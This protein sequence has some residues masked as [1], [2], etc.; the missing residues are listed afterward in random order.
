M[1][2]FAR[3]RAVP[4][5]RQT[6]AHHLEAR[7]EPEALRALPDDLIVRGVCML[8]AIMGSRGRSRAR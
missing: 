1:A 7:D 4:R 2:A 5:P 3:Q 8:K 6:S